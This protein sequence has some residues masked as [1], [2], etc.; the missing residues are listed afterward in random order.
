M[1]TTHFQFSESF[2]LVE[3]VPSRVLIY[4]CLSGRFFNMIS[5]DRSDVI[6]SLCVSR[7]PPLDPAY[8]LLL[9][10]IR[11]DGLMTLHLYLWV[12]LYLGPTKIG[13]S[14]PYLIVH[15]IPILKLPMRVYIG[16]K[17]RKKELPLK[18]LFFLDASFFF[19]FFPVRPT[20]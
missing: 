7:R 14:I 15:T 20:I 12:L 3:A 5:S 8:A 4:F 17:S 10:K 18:L 6:I 16:L 19:F 2:Y 11:P 13:L 9:A 1:L